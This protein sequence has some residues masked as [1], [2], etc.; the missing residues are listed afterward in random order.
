M[1]LHVL[2]AI[3]LAVG[4]IVST[5]AQQKEPSL[6]EQDDAQAALQAAVDATA[7]KLLVPEAMVILSTPR[8]SSRSATVPRRWARRSPPT[9][10]HPLP[11]RLEY[12][13][14]DGAV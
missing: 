2:L 14:D 9:G 8:T 3:G 11:N 12:Q 13:D 6:S 5:Y 10:R 4:L 1:K 7:K